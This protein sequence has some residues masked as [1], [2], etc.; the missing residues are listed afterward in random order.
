[1]ADQ[2]KLHIGFP[3]PGR[4][5]KMF[6]ACGESNPRQI[7]EEADFKTLVQRGAAGCERCIN[8]LM[9]RSGR[10]SE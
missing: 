2:D 8:Q 4:L 10:A 9:T 6:P 1:M 7:C 5:G 3:I